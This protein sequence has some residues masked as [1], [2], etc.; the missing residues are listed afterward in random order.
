MCHYL[1][2]KFLNDIIAN[3]FSRPVFKLIN[4]EK[5]II[6]THLYIGFEIL[7]TNN[8]RAIYGY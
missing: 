3:F 2:I 5:K 4:I 6:D 8:F 7:F 1:H